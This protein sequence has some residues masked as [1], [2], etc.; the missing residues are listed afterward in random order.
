[1]SD[2]YF[3]TVAGI[4]QFDV[5]SRELDSGQTVR[6]ATVRSIATGE[7]VRITF[8]PDFEESEFEKGDFIVVDGKVTPREYNGN[9]Y[10]NMSAR[11]VAIV[12]A[13]PTKEPEVVK[14]KGRKSF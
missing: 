2:S 12:P 14:P 6:D 8:W 7:L 3:T 1:M 10:F 4:V 9:T 5:E 11:T 13:E